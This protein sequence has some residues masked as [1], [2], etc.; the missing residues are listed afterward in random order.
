[1]ID[2]STK[3]IYY[4]LDQSLIKSDKKSINDSY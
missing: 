2:R 3:Y 1:M 4:I